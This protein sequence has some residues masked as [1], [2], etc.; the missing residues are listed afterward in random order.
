MYSTNFVLFPRLEDE[1]MLPARDL[2]LKIDMMEG[3][4]RDGY[5]Y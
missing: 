1:D 5:D 4:G 3:E 2:K